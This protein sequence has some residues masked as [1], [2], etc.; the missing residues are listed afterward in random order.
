MV[1]GGDDISGIYP[2]STVFWK[3]DDV[4]ADAVAERLYVTTDNKNGNQVPAIEAA[5]D[6]DGDG[7]GDVAFFSLIDI[8]GV[9]SI[10]RILVSSRAWDPE[11][12][13]FVLPIYQEPEGV[14]A[15]KRKSGYTTGTT[16][17][18]FNGD[19]RIDIATVYHQYTGVD[20]SFIQ[21]WYPGLDEAPDR[22]APQPPTGS[23]AHTGAP[24]P[25]T[26]PTTSPRRRNPP[27]ADSAG[28]CGCAAPSTHA[29]TH[30]LA[31]WLARRRTRGTR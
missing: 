6:M 15:G 9:G 3:V 22:T 2:N 1:L 5:G 31:T 28:G 10:G 24:N 12:P 8:C 20:V 4:A 7:L 13:V 26:A 27:A 30:P 19:G 21:L 16:V 23:T 17:G 14:A 18:D 11:A 25:T 29:T